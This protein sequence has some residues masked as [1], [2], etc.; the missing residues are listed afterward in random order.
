MQK[1]DNQIVGP[2][3]EDDIA[4]GPENLGLE[5]SEIAIRVEGALQA[6]EL[7]SL[8]SREPHLLSMGEKK[9]LAI[10]GALAVGPQILLSDE[11]TSMLDPEIRYETLAL[12]SRLQS[13]RG[14]TIVHATHRA[15][16]MLAADR[17]VLLESGLLLFDGPPEDLFSQTE[18]IV[19]QGLRVPGLFQLVRELEE[20]GFPVPRKPFCSREVADSLC[21]SN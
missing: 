2:T 10:A 6:M 9:R 17:V 3:V 18:L 20:K 5:R 12:F 4:F 16:E 21:P 7:E 11:S 1:P 13:E 19:R 8:R 15:E 14:I